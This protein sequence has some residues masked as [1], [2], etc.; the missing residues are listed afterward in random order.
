MRNLRWIGL[1]L[2]LAGLVLVLAACGGD[3]ATSQPAATTI[4]A[5]SKPADTPVPTTPPKPTDTPVPTLAPP[6]TAEEELVPDQVLKVTDL[7]SYR[8]VIDLSWQGTMTNGQE[9]ES[10]MNMAMEYVREPRAEH[11]S[12]YGTSLT[13][14]GYTAD[15]P[16]EM[17]IIGDTTYM[18]LMGSWMQ[19]PSSA[20]TE[21]LGDTFL[22]T[23]D[24]VLKN[25]KNAKYEGR[26]TVNGVDTK[27]YSFDETALESTDMAGSNFERAEGDVWI[28]VDGNY[29][30][31]MDTTMFG[32]E[33]SVPNETG[34]E[35]AAD[36]SM[37]M[38]MNVTDVNKSI[39]IEVPSEALEAG[40]PPEDVP[41]P[42][43]AAEL[44]SLF[45]MITY[46]TAKTAQEIHDFYRA[47][48][49]NNG[50]TETSDDAFGDVF[51][52]QYTKDGSTASVTITTD[53]QTGKTSV[54][55]TIQEPE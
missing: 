14:Q 5:T 41:V 22:M 38:V 40:Q 11:I 10:S 6:S 49:P 31:K 7:N 12:I 25:A 9:I 51:M 27:H 34:G 29:A 3:K 28:A 8:A 39:T 16:L 54:M 19:T 1:T 53:S 50:W 42:D 35:V 13:A 37:R 17:Y 45:G 44:T 46:T 23:S 33:L 32:K 48:M 36:G 18:N 4:P 30:V 55:I 20:G 15:Q 24:E 52:M 47:E 2:L 43:D 26:E 21:G